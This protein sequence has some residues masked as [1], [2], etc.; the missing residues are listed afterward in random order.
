[1]KHIEI[2][3]EGRK[4]VFIRRTLLINPKFQ[5][6]FLTYIVGIAAFTLAIFYAAKVF[7]FYQTRSYMMSV[8]IPA[9]H[10]IFDFLTRQSHVMN[11]IFL[12]AA[13]IEVAFLAFMG[14]K[15]S[16]RV[17]G[18]LYRLTQDMLRMAAGGPIKNIH[19]RKGDYFQEVA[20]AFNKHQE[21][22][23]PQT[24]TSETTQPEAGQNAA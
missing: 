24:T 4:H 17:A 13:V 8:G 11:W 20:E 21:R 5:L 22:H 18:P 10:M 7:F 6:S 9:D 2:D 15:I 19:F 16:H 12:A 1:M 14:L 23:V 3:S